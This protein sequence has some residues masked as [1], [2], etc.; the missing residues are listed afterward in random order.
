MTDYTFDDVKRVLH[1][2][3]AERPEYV[4]ER[5]EGADEC[6]YTDKD[7]KP[8]CLVGQVISR[9]DPEELARI[10]YDEW[11]MWTTW[12]YDVEVGEIEREEYR[13]VYIVAV[14]ELEWARQFDPQQIR[15]LSFVQAAQ[16]ASKPWGQAEE[17]ML[18]FLEGD[19][20]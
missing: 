19:A 18:R 10:H 15:A 8:S 20:D 12:E 2:V 7:G 14:D 9:L 6:T 1:E 11:G 16:D 13:P 3:V 5:P 4:Y 17:R